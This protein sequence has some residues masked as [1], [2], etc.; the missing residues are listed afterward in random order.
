MKLKQLQFAFAVL[1]FGAIFGDACA[2][3]VRT[4]Q[5]TPK[6]GDRYQNSINLENRR[7][8]ILPDGIW[9]VNNIFDDKEADWHAPWKVITL[10]SNDPTSPFKMTVVRF[11]SADIPNWPTQECEKKTNKYAF[12]QDTTGTKGARSICSS[13]FAWTNPQWLIRADLPRMF[14]FYWAKALSK[15]PEEFVKNLPPNMIALEISSSKSNGLF[16]AQDILIDADSIGTSISKLRGA[17]NHTA[18]QPG[19]S[20]IQNW[21]IAYGQSMSR[22]YLD[23]ESI[24]AG[25]YAFKA[26]SNG[27]ITNTAKTEPTQNT[28]KNQPTTAPTSTPTT[29][30]L[31]TQLALERKQ[32][33]KEKALFEEQKQLLEQRQRLEEEKK[34]LELEALQSQK[35]LLAIQEERRQLEQKRLEKLQEDKLRQERLVA[36]EAEAKAKLEA[37]RA[38]KEEERALAEE[39]KKREEAE[40]KEAAERKRAAELAKAEEEKRRKEAEA[41]ALAEKKKQIEEERRAAAEAK[42]AEDE[43]RKRLEAHKKSAPTIEVIQSE[44]DEFGAVIFDIVVSKPTKSLSIN[45]DT[46]G[47]S[48]DGKYRVKR[49]L[50][51]TGK[52]N[53]VFVAVDEYGNKA[54]HSFSGEL[55]NRSTIKLAN[56]QDAETTDTSQNS[57]I[58]NSVAVSAPTSLSSI[59]DAFVY[60]AEK[61]WAVSEKIPCSPQNYLMYSSKFPSGK[62]AVLGVVPDFLQRVEHK[63]SKITSRKFEFESKTYS[64]GNIALL[65]QIKYDPNVIV[66]ESKESIE[67]MSPT[68]IKRTVQERMMN[69]DE[70]MKT[71]RIVYSQFKTSISISG[72]CALDESIDDQKK[73]ASEVSNKIEEGKAWR[74]DLANRPRIKAFFACGEEGLPKKIAL[75]RV[76]NILSF[77]SENFPPGALSDLLRSHGCVAF[78]KTL[79][80]ELLYR[81]KLVRRAG[82]KHYYSIEADSTFVFGGFY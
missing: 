51:K 56:K 79:P 37:E 20:P 26:F 7:K 21:R 73:S 19:K 32:I 40:R 78:N 81:A 14:P 8:L 52:T 58:S 50:K 30:R 70:L 17:S 16:I 61:K 1:I 25:S 82:E 54:T 24:D 55:T 77:M 22:S 42:K 67:I 41:L 10:I 29:E 46:E 75:D 60:V 2:M 47:A 9:E 63:V 28:A 45:G 43:E 76:K 4:S 62:I 34:K 53:F 18:T 48:K 13:F 33:D 44:P 35:E 68:S 59:K 31:E 36:A 80:L 57:E 6:I 69:V 71:G 64:E 39:A 65:S 49:I 5:G 66:H 27:N 74:V 11:F 3:E 15:L 23:S 12:G 72:L 38:K